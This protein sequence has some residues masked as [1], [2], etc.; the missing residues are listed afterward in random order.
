MIQIQSRHDLGPVT[1]LYW[2]DE[3]GHIGLSLIQKGESRPFAQKNQFIEPLVQVHVRG[4][5]YPGAYSNGHTL[6]GS[7]SA[8]RFTFLSQEAAD[9]SVI[10]LLKDDKGHKIRHLALWEEGWEAIVMRSEF[11]NETDQPVILEDLSSF[12][13][14]GMTPFE[15]GDAPGV[16]VRHLYQSAWSAEGRLLSDPL[17]RLNLEPSWSGHGVRV[18]KIS[19]VGSM[20]VRGH[21]PFEAVEDV[22]NHVVWAAQLAINSSWQIEL[23]RKDD[24]ASLYGGLGDFDTAHWCKEI[25]PGAS[26]LSPEAYVTVVNGDLTD[27]CQSLLTIQKSRNTLMPKELPLLFNEYCTTWG[28]PSDE[29]LSRILEKIRGK[30]FDCL[31]MDAGWFSEGDVQWFENGGDWNVCKELF[32]HGLKDLVDRIHQAGMKAGIWFEWEDAA[33]KAKVRKHTDWMLHRH[34]HILEESGKQYLDLQNP[35]VIAYLDEKVIGLLKANG[36]DYIKVDYNGTIGIGCDGAES[37]GEGLRRNMEASKGYFRR[38]K[39]KLPE[40]MIENCSSGGHRLEPSMMEVSTMASFSDAHECPEIPVIAADLHNLIL[41]GQSQIWAVLRK[42]DSLKRLTYSLTA[43]MLGVMC[44]SGDIYDLSQEQEDQVYRG[45]SFYKQVSGVIRDGRSR[46]YRDGITSYR[47]L[48]GWQAVVRTSEDQRSC[49]V[50]AHRFA[51]DDPVR[52]QVP[53]SPAFSICSTYGDGSET[54]DLQS[55]ILTL[56]LPEDFSGVAILL[57]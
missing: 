16:L 11:I 50:V 43:A 7:P 42:E 47:H 18:E 39:E 34:G 15:P 28:V 23:K 2:T 57:Q 48:T 56:T 37:L 49:L 3:Q 52:I 31:V 21:F 27:A 29:N 26:F 35:E 51:A 54:V 17:E 1:L 6:S 36:F 20:P 53:V 33:Y 46:V 45:T 32:P 24:T 44:L 30:G 13:I 40:L 22:K 41:A 14:G 25:A 4:D 10:T 5:A 38:M 9:T 19:Q 8:Y 12:C 55:G